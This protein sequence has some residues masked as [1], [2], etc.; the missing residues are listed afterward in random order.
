MSRPLRL[1]S[2]AVA[3]PAPESLRGRDGPV[4]LHEDTVPGLRPTEGVGV[5]NDGEPVA[6]PP[7]LG[8]DRPLRYVSLGAVPLRVPLSR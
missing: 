7:G 3:F 6:A 8:S 5:T 2:V 1:P 4:P